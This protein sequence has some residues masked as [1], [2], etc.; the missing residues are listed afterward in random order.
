MRY[1]TLVAYLSN[2]DMSRPVRH[3]T[4]K[5]QKTVTVTQEAWEA[6]DLIAKEFLISRSELV[7]QIGRGKLRVLRGLRDVLVNLGR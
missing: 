7:E 4:T 2:I 5:S 3:N 6:F 1:K